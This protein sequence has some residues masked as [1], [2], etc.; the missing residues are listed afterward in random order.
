M[1]IVVL[2]VFLSLIKSLSKWSQRYPSALVVVTVVVWTPPSTG[3]R[4]IY[5]YSY[6]SQPFSPLGSNRLCSP[7]ELVKTWEINHHI[8]KTCKPTLRLCFAREMPEWFPHFALNNIQNNYCSCSAQTKLHQ[9]NIQVWPEDN[10]TPDW[11]TIRNAHTAAWWS[12]SFQYCASCEE[13]PFKSPSMLQDLCPLKIIFVELLGFHRSTKC[14]LRR[15][16]KAVMNV[17][18]K[19]N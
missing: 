5:I 10:E 17:T 11:F 3:V 16:W 4:M 13:F 9:A 2:S 14:L 6:H 19:L 15:C 18:L 8:I 7:C 12:E 1:D